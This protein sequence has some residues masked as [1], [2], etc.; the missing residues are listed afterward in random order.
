MATIVLY[1]AHCMDG[2]AS[3]WAHHFFYRADKGIS[4]HAMSYGEECPIPLTKEDDL[5][6]LDFSFPFAKMKELASQC[7]KITLIDHHATAIKDLTNLLEPN[8]EMILSYDNRN[9]G[10][11]LTWNYYASRY[12]FRQQPVPEIP[13]FIKWIEDR[14]LWR[15]QY[16]E[17]SRNFHTAASL[18]M[19]DF[20]VWDDLFIDLN[21]REVEAQGRAMRR[22]E[23]DLIEQI[24]G[25]HYAG[26][27]DE[28][29]PLIFCDCPLS[30]S[31]EVGNF[32]ALEYP[33]RIVACFH[34]GMSMVKY[35][36]RSVGDVDCSELAKFLGGGGH[37]N[38]S[39]AV[40]DIEDS[41]I[42]SILSL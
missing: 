23:K 19:K 31:S 7:R 18:M 27:S 20:E 33:D 8:V 3:A 11:G 37:K 12:S 39:G 41:H 40:V 29:Y 32:L 25:R 26:A 34:V 30:L 13:L 1:H 21:A 36:F 4:Y 10:C 14:D 22:Y 2:Y 38:A 5:V 6:I 16:G 17:A 24:A 42:N 15:F 28:R 35:S 9:S